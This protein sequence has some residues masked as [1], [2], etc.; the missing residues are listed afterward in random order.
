MDISSE[1]LVTEELRGRFGD[2]ILEITRQD[3]VK[4]IGCLRR[5]KDKAV[6]TY[7]VV[8]FFPKG[9]R[10]L[11]RFHDDIVAGKMMG[12]TIKHCSVPHVRHVSPPCAAEMPVFLRALFRTKKK[13]CGLQILNY[14][15]RSK[16]YAHIEEFYNPEFVPLRD[17]RTT[18]RVRTHVRAK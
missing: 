9:I 14:T 17:L 13:K 4:R 2:I 7:H 1:R 5:A 12:E 18:L 10:A 8:T 3:A 6:L 15:V 16:R 11:G